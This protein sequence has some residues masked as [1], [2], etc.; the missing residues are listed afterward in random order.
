MPTGTL[1]FNSH[2]DQELYSVDFSKEYFVLSTS[3]FWIELDD[4]HFTLSI[5]KILAKIVD[6]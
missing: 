4:D 5:P 1:F 3:T 6:V 2:H